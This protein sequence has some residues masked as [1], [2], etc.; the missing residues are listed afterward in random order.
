MHKFKFGFATLCVFAL[1]LSVTAVKAAPQSA[2]FAGTWN[3]TVTGGGQGRGQG[4]GGGQ[5]D[6]QN[7]GQGGDQAGG[8]ERHGGGGG[9]QSLTITQD[10]DKVRVDHK[11]PRGDNAYDATVSGNTISWI[12]ERQNREGNTMKVEYKATLDGDTLTGT[13]SG[14]RASRDFTAKRSN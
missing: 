2:N 12:E 10:G 4:Q 1:L 13:M 5:G 7:G 6:G 11:T 9:V 8:G 3:V 14:G